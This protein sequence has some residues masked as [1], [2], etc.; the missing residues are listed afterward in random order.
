MWGSVSVW[1]Q[2]GAVEV[3]DK[4]VG[5]DTDRGGEGVDCEG[6][7]DCRDGKSRQQRHWGWR[8]SHWK[9]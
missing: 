2:K 1:M 7:G 5:G 3:E 8:V 4:R 6:V 9:R